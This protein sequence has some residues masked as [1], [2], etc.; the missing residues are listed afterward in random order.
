ML[1]PLKSWA[2]IK[3][4]YRFGE[5]TFYNAHHLG[6]DYIVPI[7]TPVYAPC[8]C[9]IIF[10]GV[11][12]QGG[13]T[14]WVSWMDAAAGK[15]IMR[16]MHLKALMP[17]GKYQ[18]GAVIGQTGNTGKYTKGPHLHLDLSRQ[19]V[20][21]KDFKNF[22]DPDQYFAQTKVSNNTIVAKE[23]AGDGANS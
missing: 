2:T 8:D 14:I 18:A 11:G 1:Y 23:K 22:I 10:S 17:K 5:P 3:R 4:G 13:N 7:G 21:L 16:C 6:T 20:N 9:E 12:V 19:K 15:L